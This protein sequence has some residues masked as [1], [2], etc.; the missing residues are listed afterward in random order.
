MQSPFFVLSHKIAH[1]LLFYE[2][3]FFAILSDSIYT[4]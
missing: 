4:L 1:P 2:L 3:F